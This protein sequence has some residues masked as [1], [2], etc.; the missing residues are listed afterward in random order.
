[1]I[2]LFILIS[3][4][5]FIDAVFAPL[6][7]AQ[8]NNQQN[9]TTKRVDLLHADDIRFDKNISAD[10][11]RL[12]GNVSFQH[13]D[14]I[15]Y[16]DSAWQFSEENRFNAYSNV[17]IQVND[18]VEIYGDKL[19]YD[20][21]ARMAEL[22][23]NV[24]MIDNQMTL[25]TDNMF[26]DLETNTA[27]Y[28]DGGKI[29]DTANVL[30][31][32]W[33]F[34]YADDKNFFFKDSV[35][36]VNEDYTM[37]SDTLRYNTATEI[38]Y[39][40]GPTTIVSEEN[41]I[42]CMNGWYDTKRDIASFNEDAWFSNGEQ[43]LSGDSLYY[44]RNRGYGNAIRNVK[45]LDSVQ[46]TYVTGQ[47]AEHFEN[48]GISEV[49]IDA[50]LTVVSESDSLFMHADTLRSV[51]NEEQEVKLL[52]AYHKAKFFKTDLQGLS[53]SIVYNFSDSTIYLYENP[54]IWS[55]IHQLTA[56][57][58]EVKTKDDNNVESI[59]LF[60]AAFIVSNEDTIE[61]TFNQIK[62]KKIIGHFQGQ[63]LK[64]IDVYGNGEALY[65][66]RDELKN[67]IGINKSLSS[68]ITIFLEQNTVAR[69][70]LYRDIDANM[71]PPD[72][73]SEEERKLQRFQWIT[74][75]RPKKKE[76]IYV[77]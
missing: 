57:R 69:I 34:Y 21:N 5:L 63:E 67:M 38:S 70:I 50:V 23:G 30:T 18:S 29:V 56:D 75:T 13:E 72:E 22:Q 16:C 7:K 66:V 35:V 68:D 74:E 42:F 6:S 20:G 31:S 53:D 11:R 52:Y 59:H 45:L 77:W 2:K 25:T 76:D 15:M 24:K 36:L 4:L 64:K 19:F 28:L 40:F 71:F 39:F 55:D 12:I 47:F 61:A 43:F 14:A 33:G 27:N 3:G 41:T 37:N 60:D 54:I 46:N 51:N 48:E 8:E 65:Y 58:I 49:T 10:A 9:T 44:D 17:F 1:M 62:G 32:I 73:I 26:Y